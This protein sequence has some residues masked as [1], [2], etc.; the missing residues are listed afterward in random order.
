MNSMYFQAASLLLLP[1]AMHTAIDPLHPGAAPL[2]PA[3]VWVTAICPA[4]WLSL[5]SF[6]NE[7]MYVQ[8]SAIAAWPWDTILRTSS[9]S[10]SVDAGFVILSARVCFMYWRAWRPPP[11]LNAGFP[12]ES[13][14]CPPKAPSSWA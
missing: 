14:N 7:N 9:S 12:L 5:G 2:G 4:T 3:G 13:S 6:A 10:D 8:L 1:A 11:A